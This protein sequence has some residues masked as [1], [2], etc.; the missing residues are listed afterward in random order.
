MKRSFKSKSIIAHALLGTSLVCLSLFIPASSS[1]AEKT[2]TSEYTDKKLNIEVGKGQII[3]LKSPAASVF[4]AD[5]AIADIQVKSPHLIYVIGKKQGETNLYALSSDDKMIYSGSL[6]VNH[7]LGGL[8][9]A[10]KSVLPDTAIQIESFEGILILTGHVK[11]PS[12]AQT[13]ATMATEFIGKGSTV[14][15]KIQI[16]SPLQVNLRVRIAEVG[17]ETMKQLGINWHSIMATGSTAVGLFTGSP[18]LQGVV[19]PLNGLELQSK[20]LLGAGRGI[21]N[22]SS[23][24]KVG[25]LDMNFILDAMEKEGVLSILAEPNLTALSGQ[26]ASFLAGGEYPIPMYNEKRVVVTFKQF[27]VSLKFKPTVLKNGRI[28][29]KIQPEVSQLTTNGAVSLNG[30]TIPAL[31]TRKVDTTVELGSGQSFAIAGL[32][33]NSTTN[34]VTKFPLLGDLPIIGALFRSSQYKRNETELVI[35]VTPYIVNPHNGGSMPL[36]TDNAIIANSTDRYLHGKSFEN[37][38]TNARPTVTMKNK[39]KRKTTT[40]FMLD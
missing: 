38:G 5:P 29:L 24:F 12:Q 23:S 28:N 7:N 6:A 9:V 17:R 36:P 15:N 32:L 33:Q 20:S 30:F 13:A 22:I 31:T 25:N 1:A 8:A 10:L 3:R 11:N 27:G 21:N 34:D 26:E 37:R 16:A 14:I 19:N 2:K 18:V 40:G 35:I 39:G 4:V